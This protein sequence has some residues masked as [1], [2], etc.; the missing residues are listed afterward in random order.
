[1]SEIVFKSSCVD[2]LTD[3]QKEAFLKTFVKMAGADGSFDDCEKEFILK[4][5]GSFG[6]DS[7]AIKSLFEPVDKE[8]LLSV[9]AEIKDRGAALELVKELCILAHAD[10]ELSDE[11][12]LFLGEVGQ[13][14]GVE[15]EKI[16]E[17]SQWVIDYMI[18]KNQ[19]K[20]IFEEV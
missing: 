10:D 6:L 15:L 18:W 17:I 16:E 5:A 20:I 3:H 13:A 2:S 8:H 12:I 14:M 1:M 19:G 9:L 4:I 11:E 7:S